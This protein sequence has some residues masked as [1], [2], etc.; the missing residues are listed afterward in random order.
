MTDSAVGECCGKDNAHC[1]SLVIMIELAIKMSNPDLI[2]HDRYQRL[3]A[4]YETLAWLFGMSGSRHYRLNGALM[5][6]A[7][8]LLLICFC[9]GRG[10]SFLVMTKEGFSPVLVFKC[11]L[12]LYATHCLTSFIMLNRIHRGMLDEF[13][14]LWRFVHC[15]GDATIPHYKMMRV[16][17]WIGIFYVVAVSIGNGLFVGLGSVDIVTFPFMDSYFFLKELAVYN[18]V[19]VALTSVHFS[20]SQTVYSS[21]CFVIYFEFKALADRMAQSTDDELISRLPEFRQKHFKLQGLTEHANSMLSY[22]ACAV[23]GLN[24]PTLIMT[25]FLV[26]RETDMDLFSLAVFIMWVGVLGLQIAIVSVV[27][28]FIHYE[29]HRPLDRLQKM[30]NTLKRFRHI[31]CVFRELSLFNQ[32]LVSQEIGINGGGFFM[33]TKSMILTLMSVMVTYFALI[34]QFAMAA[35]VPCAC[36]CDVTS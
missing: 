6:S 17:T 34:L 5:Y 25:V 10:L 19:I 29:A 3:F 21:I 13:L 33:I 18:G 27:P 12:V 20:M 28:S 22:Y 32:T 36:K 31:Q 30:A 4:P 8:W 24:V 1:P 14:S 16:V 15:Y 11:L 9:L 23:Y 35:E 2:A 7:A 26:V